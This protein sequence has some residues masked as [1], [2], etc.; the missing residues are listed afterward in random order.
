MGWNK[1]QSTDVHKEQI[2]HK[3]QTCTKHKYMVLFVIC[4]LG[5]VSFYPRVARADPHAVFYTAIGQQQLFYNVLAALDQADYVETQYAREQLVE[6]RAKEEA[7]PPFRDEEF[8]LTEATKVGQETTSIT[9]PGIAD[10]L[11]RLITL[12]G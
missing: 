4:V 1:A 6:K 2:K 11:T 10:I 7:T 5:F 8:P 9:D 3:T 12:E